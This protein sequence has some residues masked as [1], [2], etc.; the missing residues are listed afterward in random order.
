[1][2]AERVAPELVQDECRPDRMAEELLKILDDPRALMVMNM[3]L[4]RIRRRLGEPGA[5]QRAARLLLETIGR[6]IPAD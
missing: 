6:E 2:A 5:A 4:A 1:V 3:G